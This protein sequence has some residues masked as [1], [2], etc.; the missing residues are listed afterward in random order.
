MISQVARAEL[1]QVRA[2]LKVAR[3]AA[4][5]EKNRRE[6]LEETFDAAVAEAVAKSILAGKFS[7]SSANTQVDRDDTSS[8][9]TTFTTAG[10]DEDH[11]KGVPLS[12][13]ALGSPRLGGDSGVVVKRRDGVGEGPRDGTELRSRDGKSSEG[14]ARATREQV[15]E[16]RSTGCDFGGGM[17]GIFDFFCFPSGGKGDGGDGADGSGGGKNR[18]CLP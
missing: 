17:G 16:R 10:I 13:K 18:F 3:A 7:D 1:R 11:V 9:C 6:K 2:A 8:S 4:S 15:E 5:A 12:E 14:A